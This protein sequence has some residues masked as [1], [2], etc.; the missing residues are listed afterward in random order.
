MRIAEVIGSVTL[1][2][3]HPCLTGP[4]GDWRALQPASAARSRDVGRR[5]SGHSSTTWAPASAA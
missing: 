4:L 2:R 1:S 5:G 3:A